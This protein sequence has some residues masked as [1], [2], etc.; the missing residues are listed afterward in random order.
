MLTSNHFLA[1]LVPEVESQVSSQLNAKVRRSKNKLRLLNSSLTGCD[2]QL[3]P[4]AIAGRRALPSYILKGEIGLL[5]IQ[6]GFFR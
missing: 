6:S 1:F 2:R 5:T 3:A 4:V